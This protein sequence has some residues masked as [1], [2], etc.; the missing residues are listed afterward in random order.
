[1][2]ELMQYF[3]Y[4]KE[5]K[6]Y[7]DLRSISCLLDHKT[8]MNQRIEHLTQK[9]DLLDRCISIVDAV[10]EEEKRILLDLI[11]AL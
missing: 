1:M 10:I 7:I 11:Q 6:D 4:L 2:R 3:V 8:I 9:Y 5:S